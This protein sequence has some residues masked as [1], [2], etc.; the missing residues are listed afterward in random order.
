MNEHCLDKLCTIVA[1]AGIIALGLQMGFVAVGVLEATVATGGLLLGVK[2]ARQ[3]DYRRMLATIKRDVATNHRRWIEH[4][5]GQKPWFVEANI[6]NALYEFEQVIDFCVPAPQDVVG[7]DL[8]AERLA[9]ALFAKAQEA[10]PGAY[11][12]KSDN[13]AAREIF[14]TIITQ[15]YQ[16]LRDHPDYGERLRTYIDEAELT[17]LGEIKQK[18]AEIKKDTE[19]LL[20][21]RDTERARARA[22]ERHAEV[23][24]QITALKTKSRR[25][26]Y[27]PPATSTRLSV[28]W[29][30]F[31]HGSAH[32][33]SAG[34]AL[35]KKRV[36]T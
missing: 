28:C 21:G 11:G 23:M 30:L 35:P 25:A 34:G 16:R 4:A 10:N 8:N 13:P 26:I 14:L 6:D 33:R 27:L 36:P 31:A 20:E 12:P 29:A 3:G 24:Q 18:T 1:A 17:R 9:A 15:T 5:H 7:A 32:C 19:A 2:R 22:E